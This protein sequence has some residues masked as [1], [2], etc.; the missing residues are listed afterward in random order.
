MN[1]NDAIQQYKRTKVMEAI[2][3]SSTQNSLDLFKQ[4]ES[5]FA[6]LQPNQVKDVFGATLLFYEMAIRKIGKLS[7]L[8][9]Y[10]FA[11]KA[12][13]D[14]NLPNDNKLEAR[15]LRL[16]SLFVN[17]ETFTRF[18]LLAASAPMMKYE[19]PLNENEFFDFIIMSDAYLIWNIEDN[20]TVLTSIKKLVKEHEAYHPRF[21]KATIIHEGDI[22]HKALLTAISYA[23]DYN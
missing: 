9:A 7:P 2:A 13:T 20:G 3:N 15:K 19:G 6:S 23:I 22:A 21:N 10:Y 16:K 4:I 18:I 1:I 12:I 11:T 8:Y 17:L 5:S 14:S